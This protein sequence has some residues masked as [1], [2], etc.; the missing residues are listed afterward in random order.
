MT[1]P[2]HIR[3]TPSPRAVGLAVLALAAVDAPL[4]AA[5]V[6]RL[7]GDG[8]PWEAGVSFTPGSAIE[9]R[10]DG[11]RALEPLYTWRSYAT[12]AETLTAVVD[13]TGGPWLRPFFAP[14]TLNLAQDGVRD[15]VAHG[16]RGNLAMSGSCNEMAAFL[17]RVGR[18]F[19]G[20]PRT[21]T[22][23]NVGLGTPKE[24]EEA[25]FLAQ[26][27][28]VDLGADYP[29]ERVRFF[30]RL[31]RDNP[32]LDELLDTMGRPRLHPEELGEEDF[33]DHYLPW[34]ELSGASSQVGLSWDCSGFGRPEEW[35]GQIPHYILNTRGDS[36]LEV[37]AR[38]LANQDPIVEVA[39]PARPLQYIA[40]RPLDLLRDY[41][42]AELQVFGRGHVPRAVYTSTVLDLGGPKALGELRWWGRQPARSRVLVRTRS[43]SDGEPLRY[44]LPGSVPGEWVETTR[45]EYL[46]APARERRATDDEVNWSAWSVPYLWDEALSEETDPRRWPGGTPI[47]SPG[48][49]PYLQVQVLFLSEV[50]H[51]AALRNLDLR[52]SDPA[53]RDLVAEIWPVEVEAGQR[54]TFTYSLRPDL[55]RNDPGFDR[56]EIFTLIRADSVRSVT[57]D[58][59]ELGARS[60]RIRPDRIVV[61]LPRLRGERDTAKLVQVVFDARVVR[62]ATEF[63]SRV[64]DVAGTLVR[65]LSRPGDADPSLPGNALSVRLSSLDAG[66]LARVRAV[67]AVLSPNGDGANEVVQFHFDLYDVIAERDLWVDLYTL[68]GDR[69]RRLGPI[70][71]RHGAYGPTRPAPAWDGRDEDGR[72]VPPGSYLFRLSVDADRGQAVA[73][74]VVRVVY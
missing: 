48:P 44:W 12:W 38:E 54:V 19:D 67:P 41:E 26:S 52:F 1:H 35:F 8:N 64:Y 29:V 45:E 28:I 9:L 18:M 72:P 20:N 27:T 36:R 66:P 74:G 61:S 56:L 49:A 21:A 55:V 47:L 25:A 39:F 37:L 5:S 11:T 10:G 51:G 68:G 32:R 15:R 62:Y 63:R 65:Q 2:H 42:I 4:D 59:V 7:G 6:Y 46:R 50:D 73:T 60:A 17:Y 58:R 16:D 13:S 57:V 31:G 69:V 23:F 40:L 43:G 53:A 30:P 24:L 22:Y 71:V 14:D 33:A 70:G 3:A 34:F